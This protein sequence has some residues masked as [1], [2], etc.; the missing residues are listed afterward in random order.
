MELT[1]G[2]HFLVLSLGLKNVPAKAA[3]KALNNPCGF[4]QR[5]EFLPFMS[6]LCASGDFYKN[7]T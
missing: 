4:A 7:S 3:L 5:S 1:L 6:H 2:P